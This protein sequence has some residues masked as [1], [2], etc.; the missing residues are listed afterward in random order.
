MCDVIHLEHL[1]AGYS[2]V[3]GPEPIFHTAPTLSFITDCYSI[4]V[5]A[6]LKDN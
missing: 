3:L 6:L 5:Q 4:I 2:I 1:P